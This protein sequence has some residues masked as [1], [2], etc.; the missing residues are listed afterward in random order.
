MKKK[1]SAFLAWFKAQYGAIPNERK[2]QQLGMKI[3]NLESDLHYLKDELR[4]EQYL[5]DAR[6]A[7]LKGW[8]AAPDA[9]HSEE[10]KP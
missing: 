9:A 2:R 7:A 5:A 1:Q 4:V 8:T 10:G 6:S 3:R